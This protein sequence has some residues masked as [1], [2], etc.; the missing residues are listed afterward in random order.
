MGCRITTD[1]AMPFESAGETF[2]K[3][4]TSLLDFEGS[5]AN[6]LNPTE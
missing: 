4:L 2:T 5:F 3:T 6:E 1:S